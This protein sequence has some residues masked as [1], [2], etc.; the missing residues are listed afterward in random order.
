MIASGSGG[1]WPYIV[2]AKYYEHVEK[3][4]SRALSYA[5]GALNYYL[6]ASLLHQ[7]GCAEHEAILRRIERLRRKQRLNR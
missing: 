7:E 1:T 4:V 2:L 3:D 6:N 5:T